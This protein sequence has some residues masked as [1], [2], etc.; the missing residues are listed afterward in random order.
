MFALDYVSLVKDITVGYTG[1]SWSVGSP[2]DYDEDD[3]TVTSITAYDWGIRIIASNNKSVL[4][5]WS[6]VIYA[7]ER[8]SE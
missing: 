5:P 2:A 3:V 8:A 6:N 4:V 1:S 7:K